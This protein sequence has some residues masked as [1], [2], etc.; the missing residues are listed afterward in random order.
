MS[1]Q[2]FDR[3]ISL[4]IQY[5]EQGKYDEALVTL[6]AIEFMRGVPLTATRH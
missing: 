3:I 1:P 4:A 6:T 2:E 5:L